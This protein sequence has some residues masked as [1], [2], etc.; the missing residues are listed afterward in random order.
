MAAVSGQLV[1]YLVK[2]GQAF[3]AL[4]TPSPS[5]VFPAP[6]CE[7]PSSAFPSTEAEHVTR[8]AG[9]DEDRPPGRRSGGEIA[10]LP[11][12][13]RRS[14]KLRRSPFTAYWRAGNVTLRPAPVR[15]S[16]MPKPISFSAAR[17]GTPRNRSEPSIACR[18]RFR[19]WGEPGRPRTHISDPRISA[20][21]EFAPP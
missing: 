11:K 20:A 8:H 5:P 1:K 21:S 9:A 12:K 10:F 13:K 3:Q 15:R 2:R 4:S 18:S 7:G 16:Q 6:G 17:I 14:A 19:G